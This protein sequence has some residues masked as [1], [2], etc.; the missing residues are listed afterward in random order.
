MGFVNIEY[1]WWIIPLFFGLAIILRKNFIS[2]DH[3]LKEN[4]SFM[5][6][7]KTLKIFMF[8]TRFVIFSLIIIMLA[9]PFIELQTTEKGDP[10][11][12]ILIDNST[13]MSAFETG[14]FNN[15]AE[16]LKKEIPVKIRTITSD[17][18]TS[19]IG[20]EVISNLEHAT[21][22]L[23]ISDMQVTNGI[24]MRDAMTHSTL[25]NSTIS[26]IS[27]SSNKKDQSV[28]IEADSKTTR[29]KEMSFTIHVNKLNIDDYNIIVSIDGE[30][31]YNARDNKDS[32]TLTHEFDVGQHTI[33]AELQGDDD[34]PENNV[35]RK[36]IS[37]V[38][39]PKILYVTNTNSKLPEILG[40]LYQ[41]D[42]KG[43]IPE[44]LTPYYAVIIEDMNTKQIQNIDLL[45]DFAAEGNGIFVIGGVNS[46]DRGGYKSSSFETLLPVKIGRGD[47][48]Q[49]DSNIVILIDMSGS[50][51]NY[52]VEGDDGVLVE[53]KDTKPLDVIKALAVDVIETLNRGNN[54]GVVAFAIPDPENRESA[55]FGAQIISNID[56]LGNIKEV[57]VDKISRI[58]TQG[59]S[60][61]DV[62]F[63]GA[64]TLLKHETG[65]RN[66]ILI[67]DG[68][69]NVFSDLKQKAA[70][71]VSLM[72]DQ[73]IKT[74]TVG[75]G[76][77][78]DKE[79]LEE[80]AYK[81]KGL[82][83][84]AGQENKLKILFGTPEE[85]EQGDEMSLF[86]LNPTHFITRDFT[87]TAKIYGFNQVIPKSL[88]RVIVTTDSGEPA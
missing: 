20:D 27:L 56:L 24:S 11:I 87:P 59:Q 54:V 1:L 14:F 12:T 37:V 84:P 71:Q 76:R 61:F 31:I 48:K 29:S 34:F 51:Q 32:I 43:Q 83:F 77:D 82:Y 64:Y 26:A 21:N 53:V 46:F 49:G 16:T 25:L 38:P 73:G 4:K 28:W 23:L 8:I 47:K 52:W 42:K 35:F 22:I 45:S 15:L 80:L 41:I 3:D 9:R 2:I 86:V 67:S 74:Y 6:R 88:A 78:V 72:A 5:R 10:K 62:G 33:T 7:R 18:L 30:V 55:R 69:K 58:E 70:D 79:Y 39:Q 44:D 60:L 13:S 17:T 66:I 57:A 68:G 50:T 85:K 36:T 63:A 75:V 81:G 65:S 19:A 40:E